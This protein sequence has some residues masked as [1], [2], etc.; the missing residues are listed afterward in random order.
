MIVTDRDACFW[1]YDEDTWYTS[2]DGEFAEPVK[3]V[4]DDL[5]ACPYCHGRIITSRPVS[6]YGYEDDEDEYEDEY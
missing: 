1:V 6:Y 5:P 3:G 2:C 4:V